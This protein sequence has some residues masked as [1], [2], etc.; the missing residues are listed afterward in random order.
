V[1]VT[2]NE[3]GFYGHPDHV[4]ANRITLAAL[5][6]IDYEPTLYYNA[7]PN[8]VIARYRE[9]WEQEDRERREANAAKGLVEPEVGESNQE[10]IDMGTPDE[11]IGASI[12]VSEVTNSKYDALA[13]HQSQMT[14]AF[15]LKMDREQFKAMMGREWFVRVTNS[16][17]LDGVVEDIFVG[18]R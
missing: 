1:I 7:I 12:D 6:L 15:W 11:L 17:K 18:Y 14:D 8:T 4:Q 2:Y 3:N 5:E 9:R 10:D 16:M 13:A